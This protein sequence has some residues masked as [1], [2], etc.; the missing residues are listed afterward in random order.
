LKASADLD[1]LEGIPELW[2][3]VLDRMA[4]D[5]SIGGVRAAM[6]NELRSRLEGRPALGEL[7]EE[8]CLSAVRQN[9][10][11][12][13]PSNISELPGGESAGGPFA[14]ELA[15][16]IRHRPTALLLAAG[17]VAAI[18]EN[19]Q[20]KLS[21]A[22]RLPRDLV[23]EAARLI[24]GSNQALQH[25]N[26][27]VGQQPRETDRP[28]DE[29]VLRAVQPMAASLL[30]A[31]TPG[32][33]PHP[34]SVPRLQGAYLDGAAW[35]GL[36][37]AEVNLCDAELRE[38]DLSMA[39]LRRA[40]ADRARFYRAN[41]QG[42]T[43]TDWHV[44]GADL[45]HADLRWVNAK[46]ARFQGANLSGA[47]L[48]EANL[49]KADLREALI[50]D[51]DFTGANLEESRLVRLKLRLARFE[52]ARFGGAD[53]RHSDL[54]EIELTEADFHDANLQGA[55]LTGS[56][57]PAANFLGANLRDAGLAEVH[58]PGACL[59]DA[60]LRGASF[61][62]GSAR[63]GLVDSP[64][65]CEGSRTGFYTDDYHDQDIKPAEE[66]RKANLRGA[67]LCGAA[68][69]DVDFYLVDLRDA[70]YTPDQ[71][72]HFRRCRAILDDHTA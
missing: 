58:W 70:R 3:M 22:H 16:L 57:L 26:D 53:L 60:D 10:S 67:D 15:R 44:E 6:W 9:S 72:E 61:H 28:L 27:W 43:L 66:I 56:R 4:C 45:S 49:W 34:E 38:A 1:F 41:L 52:G 69:E 55:L 25:L 24:A 46:N 32:W 17:R 20:G 31:A 11:T 71:A 64:I 48:I 40:H 42:A 63:S 29:S 30:H 37:L 33:R 39:N 8:F 35:S 62:L 54:E 47:S 12:V 68:I 19:G 59:R 14:V 65:A 21:L 7:V 5:E 18:V 2:T 13:I 51:A 23:Q 36:N 50:E